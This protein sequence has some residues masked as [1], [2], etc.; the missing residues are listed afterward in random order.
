MVKANTK[1]IAMIELTKKDN[2]H[3]HPFADYKHKKTEAGN[4]FNTLA[5]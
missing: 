5:P 2:N 1:F 4:P 3:I